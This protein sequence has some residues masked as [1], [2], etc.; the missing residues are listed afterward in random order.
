MDGIE[1]SGLDWEL[2]VGLKGSAL[3]KTGAKLFKAVAAEITTK[4]ANWAAHESAKRLVQWAMDDLGVVKPGRQFNL[5]PSPLSLS[6][7]AGIFYEW[8]TLHLLGGKIGWQYISPKWF[9]E[10]VN[11]DVWLQMYNIPEQDGEQVRVGF[12]IPEWGL[13][14]YIR[15]KKKKGEAHVKDYQIVG[16]SYDGF[17]FERRDGMGYSGINLSNL[18]P[19][20]RLE[21]GFFPSRTNEVQKRGVLKVRPTVFQFGNYQYWEADDTAEMMLGHDGGFLLAIHDYGKVKS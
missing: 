1:T 17:L 9:V 3:L 5:L 16:Y 6:V 11:G 19:V 18:Q 12:S 21:E 7:G 4:V 20:G 15:W 8:Q 10:R 13:D 2:A 14:P